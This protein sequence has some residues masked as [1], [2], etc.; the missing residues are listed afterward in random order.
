[1]PS[2]CPV[3]S[4]QVRIAMTEEDQRGDSPRVEVKQI[5]VMIPVE[6]RDRQ[7]PV[8]Q[9]VQRNVPN[10]PTLESIGTRQ[11]S[12]RLMQRLMIHSISDI[13]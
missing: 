11:G 2:S 4:N 5:R 3:S 8:I 9:S 6:E 7:I 12:L 1:M 13:K 10:V